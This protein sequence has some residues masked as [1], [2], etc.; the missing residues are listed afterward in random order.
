MAIEKI[1]INNKGGDEGD[2]DLLLLLLL[3]LIKYLFDPGPFWGIFW[4]NGV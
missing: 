4:Q 2:D 1:Q 3:L